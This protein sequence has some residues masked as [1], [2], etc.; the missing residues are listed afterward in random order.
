MARV[1]V[2]TLEGGVGGYRTARAPEGTGKG[3]GGALHGT[4]YTKDV[5]WLGDRAP[6]SI[7]GNSSPYSGLHCISCALAVACFT[8]FFC[9]AQG[10]SAGA[11]QHAGPLGAQP[12]TI[13][14]QPNQGSTQSSTQAS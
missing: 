14:A 13:S 4:S 1:D 10:S 3:R 8:V 5:S 7:A 12:G 2:G 6:G 9:A 11:A